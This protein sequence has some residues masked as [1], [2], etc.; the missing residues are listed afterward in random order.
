MQPH[1]YCVSSN[2]IDFTQIV[3]KNKVLNMYAC[4][5]LSV[6]HIIKCFTYFIVVFSRMARFSCRVLVMRVPT[7]IS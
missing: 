1:I 6:N 4:M 3:N 2:L 5:Q 7:L